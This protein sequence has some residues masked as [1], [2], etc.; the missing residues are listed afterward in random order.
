MLFK[1][2]GSMTMQANKLFVLMV[3][4]TFSAWFPS[5][6]EASDLKE[7]HPSFDAAL[8]KG[9]LSAMILSEPKVIALF[10]KALEEMRQ[11]LPTI[12]RSPLFEHVHKTDDTPGVTLTT[13]LYDQLRDLS[14][15]ADEVLGFLEKI[16]VTPNGTMQT[17]LRLHA[18]AEALK[19]ALTLSIGINAVTVFDAFRAKNKPTATL[20]DF[21]L[22]D[23]MSTF[24]PLYKSVMVKLREHT[25]FQDRNV[26]ELQRYLE[27]EHDSSQPEDADK[28]QGCERHREM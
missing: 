26:R 22:S 15:S 13:V 18:Q 5:L 17:H 8:H 20:L 24:L 16:K 9:A 25:A 10:P 7:E 14:H 27:A 2:R 21:A 4:T 19:I 1:P 28:P 23:E 11:S 3:I 6:I 12:M